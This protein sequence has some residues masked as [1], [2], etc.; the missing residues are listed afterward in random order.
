MSQTGPAFLTLLKARKRLCLLL[1]SITALIALSMTPAAVYGQG[2]IL[3]RRLVHGG[4]QRDYTLYVPSNYTPET[5]VPLV[6]NM[7]GHNTSRTVQMLGSTMNAVAEQEGFL[8]AYPDAI[9]ANWFGGQ[10]N[11]GFIDSVLREISS[12]YSVNPYRIYS[13]GFSQG[14]MMSYILGAERPNIFAAIA[15]VA[16]IFNALPS[17]ALPLLHMHGTADNVVPYVQVDQLLPS[18]V[19]RNGGDLTASITNLPDLVPI[20]GSTVQL[21]AYG[22]APYVDNSGQVREAEVLLYRIE[23]GGHSWP[24]GGLGAPINYDINASHEIW[25][26]FSRHQLAAPP[27]WRS[28]SVDADGD[29]SHATNWTIGVPNSTT[30]EAHFGAAIT[31]PHMVAVDIPITVARITFDSPDSY[32]IAGPEAIRLDVSSGNAAIDVQR[33]SHVISAPVIVADN[34]AVTV[35]GADNNL[36]FVGGLTGTGALLKVGTGSMT[37]SSIQLPRLLL[38]EGTLTLQEDGGVSVL[39][40]LTLLASSTA[41]GKLDLANN[42]AIIDYTG[43]SPAAELRQQ[44]MVGRGG[45]GL[46]ATWTGTGITS[47]TAA[48]EVAINPESRSIGYAENAA[49]PLGPY[50]TFHGVAVD[51]T[52]VL[53][54]YTRTGDANLDGVVDDVDVTILSANYAPGVPQPHW[55]LGD[56]DYNGFVD[57]ADVTL[58]GVFYDPTAEP[59]LTPAAGPNGVVAVPEPSNVAL[60]LA[61]FSTA[62]G[63]GVRRRMRDPSVMGRG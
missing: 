17:R 16:G 36:S 44:I 15:P 10:D 55:A 51:G 19:M 34:T 59:L 63:F 42:A 62:V 7:H 45:A 53:M 40:A 21:R 38:S 20:D 9:G 60:I 46:G 25:R 12:Q 54:A 4:L 14:G 23:N 27:G 35:V 33:G 26:F 37:A 43:N 5:A 13:T 52:S 18:Y 57:D 8:V 47:S 11:V 31:A 61:A 48:A 1:A 50:E 22:G 29:W 24:G 6:I 56:F 30:A 28:W 49:L 58:L 39:G 41:R 32:T 3:E 2:Q